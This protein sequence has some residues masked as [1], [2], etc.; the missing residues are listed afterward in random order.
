MEH[1]LHL[2]AKHFVES[3]CPVSPASV[4][5]KAT[6]ALKMARRGAHLNMEEFDR[7]MYVVDSDYEKSFAADDY[8]VAGEDSGDESDDWESDFTSGDSLGKALGLVKQVS[9]D[10]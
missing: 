10:S 3:V 2:A 1:S 6:A 5:K 9:D 7:A 4:L 8:D